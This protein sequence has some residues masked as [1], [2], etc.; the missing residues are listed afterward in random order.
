MCHS[1]KLATIKQLKLCMNCFSKGHILKDCKST[2]N[3]QKCN[4]RHN[5][6]L[7]RN[8]SEEEIEPSGTQELQSTSNTESETPIQSCF[9]T[10]S[11]SVL[12]GTAIVHIVYNGEISKARALLD[13]GS[14]ASFISERMFNMLKLPS[15]RTAAHVSGLNETVSARSRKVCSLKLSSPVDCNFSLDV[16]AFVIPKLTSCLPTFSA[17]K[18]MFSKL[19]EIHLADPDFYRSSYVD[20]LIGA[21][22]FPIVMLQGVINPVCGTL[23]AQETRFGWILT[24]PIQTESIS[25]FQTTV[26]MA[27]EAALDQ[28]I[29]RFWEMEDIPKGTYMSESDR[30]CEVNFCRTTRR[31][32]SGRFVVTLPFK[33]EYPTEIRLGESRKIALAQYIRNE[34]RLSRDPQL[35]RQYDDVL[36]EYIQ[37]GHMKEVSSISES[38]EVQIHYLPHHAVVRPDSVT[39]KVRVVFNASNPTSNGLSL[40]DILHP[41]PPLQRDLCI[42]LLQWRLYKIVFSSDIEKMYRQI[43]VDP[44]HIPFQRILFRKSPQEDVQEFELQTVTFGV[45]CAPFLALRTIQ[46][47]ASDVKDLYPLPSGVLNSSMY[48]DDVLGGSHDINSA[49]ECQKQLID[50]LNSAGFSLRKWVSNSKDFLQFIPKSNLLSNEF[51]E[52]ED[53]SK[54]KMLGT[55]YENYPKIENIQI[56]RWV[57]YTPESDI[58]LHGFCDASEK[59]Y[60]ASLYLRV[61]TPNG[62]IIT[63]LLISKS[64]VAPLKTISIPRLELC[65]ALLLAQAIESVSGSIPSCKVFCWTDSMIVLAW[66]KKPPFLWKTFVANRVSKIA[67]VVPAD[68][69]AH[70][71]SGDN[72]ADLASRGAFPQ[73][74]F[75]NDLWWYGPFWL[76]LPSSL[77]P[78]QMSGDVDGTKLEAKIIH[79]HFAYFQKYEDLLDR[80][81]SLGR[82]LRV[83]AFVYRFIARC[84]ISRSGQTIP[85]SGP[86]TNAEIQNVQS[87]FVILAQKVIYP[88]E[89]RALSN[90]DKISVSSPLCNLNPFL[91]VN[92]LMRISSRIVSSECLSYSERFPIIVPY[93][94]TFSVLLVKFIHSVTLHGGNS[95]MLRMLRL[96][97]WIPKAKILIKACIHRCKI[98]VISKHKL[99]TQLMGT[100]PR[101]RTTLSRPFTNT[102]IDFA[103]PFDIKNYAARSC[104]IT[105]GYVCLFVCFATR[106]IHLELTSSL[107]TPEFLAA[108]HRFVSRRGCPSKLFS[109]NG[110]TFVGASKEIARDFFQNSRDMTLSQFSH[111]CL[112]WHFIPPGAPHMG[113]LWEAGVKS[114]K[115]HFRKLAG[116][117]KFTF[118]EFTTILSRIEAC[119]NSR[120]ISPM[121]ENPDDLIA[122]TPGHF[123]IGGPLLSPAEP[124]EIETNLSILN[125]WRRV[126]ALSQQFSIRWKHEYLKEL[127]KRIKWK[128]PQ[129]NIEVGAMVVVRDD[130]L[131]PNEWKLG[132]ISKIYH[133]KD[134]L[135]R[136]VDIVTQKGTITRPLYAVHKIASQSQSF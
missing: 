132:R 57:C 33:P 49:V 127:H 71:Q 60:A 53:S 83:M 107:T 123:L 68:N 105:K 42:L 133:G 59:A 1:E 91:D 119:L 29:L 5:T 129:P 62:D 70:V 35:K 21:D 32:S 136:V 3:C 101:E 15:R 48:V 20:I 2:F 14:E 111:Q 89:Y 22:V 85:N 66:L 78:I 126:V 109:D 128:R 73:D 86:L 34:N 120:P 69:W 112:T 36:L 79:S 131:P 100:L 124:N 23:M 28:Q 82:A 130:C 16:S 27:N 24:G 25:V 135:V 81:S 117:H 96:Q 4:K 67:A 31:D 95:L 51:L 61:T 6:L 98:C 102:G 44:K 9:A 13:S 93:K 121:S 134:N 103:G 50:A 47:L 65:G 104:T 87:Q 40:N 38:P 52:F 56:P 75:Q 19:P 30:Y 97:F 10:N 55:F 54:A 106:A 80:F 45:I 18:E 115:I 116:A 90:G 99:Q 84:R 11:K 12:L 64:R 108:F 37:L 110:K 118:E 122:L 114:F 7:H 41:G 8:G 88:R 125:R 43:C 26:L 39:T 76:R 113:G 63:H 58:Q 92:G 17:S 94:C 74:L 77:W 46:Q 72:P